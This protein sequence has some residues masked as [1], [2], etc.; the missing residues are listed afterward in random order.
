MTEKDTPHHQS[1]DPVGGSVRL[2]RNWWRK[3]C[4]EIDQPAVIE[5][6][7]G[8]SGWTPRYAFM[9]SMSAGIAILGLLLSSPAVIIGAMLLSPLMG[10]IMGMGFALSIG[11][12][13][14][15]RQSSRALGLG[16]V[17]AILFCTLIVMISPIQ[18]ITAE[19][20]ARTRPNLFD[21][22]VALFSALAGAYAMIRGREG[23]IVGVAIATALMPP[24]A[25]IGFGLA[26]ANW[27]VFGG[28]LFLFFTN[29]M[30]IALT[31]AVMA[32]LYGFRTHL[33]PKQSIAQSVI[34]LAVFIA[35]AVPLGFSLRQIAWEANATSQAQGLVRD[36]FGSA[37]RVSQ[38]D[39]DFESHPIQVTAS[40]LT[41]EIVDG[42]EERVARSLERQLSRPF[43]VSI[44]QYRVG[45]ASDAAETAQIAVARMQE[46][47]EAAEREVSEI[48][49]SFALLAGVSPNDV[50]VDNRARRA[51]VRARPLPGAG[52][53]TYRALEARLAAARPEWRLRLVPPA[54]P[55]PAI[56]IENGDTDET[57]SDG[58][59]LAIWA[60]ERVGAPVGVTGADTDAEPVM[61]QLREREIRA[62]RVAG[63][64][65]PGTVNLSWL[66]PDRAVE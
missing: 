22:A 26:I 5:K 29:L 50:T 16:I 52:L 38:L 32:R 35:L 28:A 17:I 45:T 20:A 36:Q 64:A 33:S 19:I 61:S 3:I 66:A 58:L 46:Q 42:A 63:T 21:L 40:V 37:A 56:G 8:E 24:L 30:T 39:L 6:I 60:A 57:G 13:A 2:L 43:A 23:T 12:F 34:I 10:P 55:L 41:P 44:R 1:E 25:V 15:L 47:A 11:D 51:T 49:Q 31:A 4:R 7:R 27:Q 18:T 62:V 14:W 54:M 59:E 48:R 65:A 9:T 53:D